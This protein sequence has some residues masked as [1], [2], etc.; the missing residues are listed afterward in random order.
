MA[1]P[2]WC[3]PPSHWAGVRWCGGLKKRACVPEYYNANRIVN[4][5]FT[6]Y[7]SPFVFKLFYCA[8]FCYIVRTVQHPTREWNLLRQKRSKIITSNWLGTELFVG[9]RVSVYRMS[10]VSR[11]RKS[12]IQ[13]RRRGQGNRLCHPGRQ[14][15]GSRNIT[16]HLWCTHTA[17]DSFSNRTRPPSSAGITCVLS[18]IT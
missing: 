9:K 12:A 11:A 1:P 13:S 18:C 3:N 8:F 7:R 2:H 4:L 10:P 5:G 14:G 6:F 16:A 15:H 17:V